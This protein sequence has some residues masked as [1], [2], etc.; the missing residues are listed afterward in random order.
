LH[1]EFLDIVA[2]LRKKFKYI[3]LVTNGTI[4]TKYSAKEIS[5]LGL[6]KIYFSL[7]FIDPKMYKQIKGGNLDKIFKG[8]K[9]YSNN[10]EPKTEIQVN[11]LYTKA[12][13]IDELLETYNKLCLILKD[14]W[15]IYIRQIKDLAGQI[16]IET[17]NDEDELEN[18]LKK[19]INKHFIVENW[20]N[21]LKDTNFIHD[22]PKVCRHIYKYYMLLWNGDVVPC[23]QDFNAQLKLFNVFD[24]S[25]NLNKLFSTDIYKSFFIDME[26]LNYSKYNLCQSC[27]DYYRA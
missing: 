24:K 9:T 25:Y 20:N 7:D 19:Y 16:N 12:T 2:R 15:S 23:C 1:P 11:Y 5:D 22:N 27:K 3:S 6:D 4:F 18:K 14:N 8:M 26:M 13:T 17:S 21:Y 10:N